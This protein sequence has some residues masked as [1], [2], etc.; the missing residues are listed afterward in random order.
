MFRSIPTRL[1]NSLGLAVGGRMLNKVSPMKSPTRS[2]RAVLGSAST[3]QSMTACPR[4]GMLPI[5]SGGVDR[6]CQGGGRRLC[7]ADPDEQVVRDGQDGQG[8]Q[9]S[10]G[11][12][13]RGCSTPAP[14]HSDWDSYERCLDPW[15]A[16][17]HSAHRSTVYKSP[18]T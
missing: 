17:P 10:P 16:W 6:L 1:G 8:R 4:S 9:F 13:A 5:S 7:V 12:Q 15:T 11:D 3:C 2:D 18:A 14:G